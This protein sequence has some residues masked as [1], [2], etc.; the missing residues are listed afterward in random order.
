MNHRLL[1]PPLAVMLIATG[2]R[3]EVAI[4]PSA[5]GRLGAWLL[6]GPLPTKP[7]TK[8]DAAIVAD[9]EAKLVGRLG[10][11]LPTKAK[12][13]KLD[14]QL[15]SSASR[16]LSITAATGHK[17][18]DAFALL[19]GVL[20]LTEPLDGALLMGSSGEVQVSIDGVP[21]LVHGE[22]GV[23][24]EDEHIVPI[25]LAK[26]DHPILIKLRHRQG[27]WN[28]GVR[29]VDESLASPQGASILLPGMTDEQARALAGEMASVDLHRG[30]FEGGYRPRIHVRY[31]QGAPRLP[32]PVRVMGERRGST[33]PL[34]QLTAEV[35]LHEASR[36]ELDIPL[37]PLLG[38]ELRG[39]EP[40][41][42]AIEIAGKTTRKTLS[43][44]R[45]AMNAVDKAARALTL[46]RDPAKTPFLG[47]RAI[48]IATLEHLRDELLAHANRGEVDLDHEISA[49][50]D[51]VADLE[52]SRDP[53][54]SR[55]GIRRFAHRSPLDGNLSPFGLY[56]PPSYQ[57]GTT[58]KHPLVVALQGMNGKPLSMI[59]WFFGE[60]DPRR[61]SAWEDRH[62]GHVTPIDAFVVAPHAHGNAMF[63]ELGEVDTM[64]VVDWVERFFPIDDSRVTVTGVSMGGTGAAWMALRFP[65][66]FAAAAPLCGYH[67]YFIR[68]DIRG[69]KLRPWERKLAEHRSNTHWA[70]NGREIPLFVWHGQRDLPMTH[71]T[72][73][74]DR[75]EKLG[76][77]VE[78][79]HPDVGHDV[80]RTAY[81]DMRVFKWLS[82]KRRPKDPS[83]VVFKTSSLR[84]AD[85]HWVKV[86]GLADSLSFGEVDASI[87]D[88]KTIDVKTKG[89]TALELRRVDDKLTKTEAL[90]VRIDGDEISFPPS[91]RIVLQRASNG[92]WIAGER[93]PKPM[94]KRRGLSGPIRDIFH[95]PLV[96]VVGTDDPKQTRA[97]YEVAKHF[98]R[99]RAGVDVAYPIIEDNALDDD[100]ASRHSLVL[101]G[102]SRSNR[103]LRSLEDRLPFRVRDGAIEANGQRFEGK[104]AGVA[105]I[106]PNPAHPDR[107]LLAI[108]G[109]TP[110]GTLRATSLPDLLP[111]WIIYDRSLAS[112]KGRLILGNAKPL[113]AGMFGE[114]WSLTI[115]K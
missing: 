31:P 8:L 25:S 102:N 60:D 68:S 30:L 96:F 46:V 47:D 78:R 107:Y 40:I 69:R 76:Y 28:F 10:D 15:A 109:A 13:K 36:G 50:D 16:A 74:I 39:E 59:R 79:E 41:T 45:R 90:R 44:H 14:W 61:D 1:L 52:A 97:N 64:L 18:R 92:H 93:A 85:S 80:W 24:R 94:E 87:R 22:P 4:L 83:R 56:V 112:A 51:Y 42:V 95:E 66:T 106:H 100:M 3:A 67:D 7:S 81:A 37:P 49:I 86:L 91:E 54:R 82:S 5:E 38:E 11:A 17:G 104:E 23:Y 29:L 72:S 62:P 33:K 84:Y 35:P 114:D 55:S 105:F 71:S 77:P 27:A 101:I 63:R 26:G 21:V 88:S 108:Q 12:G 6:A 75:Y 113:A 65:D 111:D 99:I 53:L 115:D 34:F 70:E 103:V 48:A 32:I 110:L 2:A 20:R 57:A 73:L 9:D 58:R 19:S 43:P 98:A 89:I